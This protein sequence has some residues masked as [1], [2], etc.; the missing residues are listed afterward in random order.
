MELAERAQ[1]QE[2][3]DD[4]FCNPSDPAAA[5]RI[6]EV[7]G[8]SRANVIG[9]AVS[10]QDWRRLVKIACEELHDDPGDLDARSRL[11]LLMV[12]GGGGGG[13]DTGS[14]RPMS[15]A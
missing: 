3:C 9:D 1:I 15:A 4:L 2:A 11:L 10:L 13:T 8:G 5:N 7:L 14:S 6:F 12:A